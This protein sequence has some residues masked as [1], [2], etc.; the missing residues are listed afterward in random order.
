MLPRL[1]LLLVFALSC[2]ASGCQ[3]KGAMTDGPAAPP[4]LSSVDLTPPPADLDP[5]GDLAIACRPD[6]MEFTRETGC[7]SDDSVEFCLSDG[8]AD[9]LRRVKQAAPAVRCPQKGGG[10]ARCD[11]NT[12]LLCFY[13]TPDPACMGGRLGEVE[14]GELCALSTF[15]EI[16]RIVPTFFE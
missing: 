7:Q 5:G 11:R 14:W 4:D 15:P 13:P 9:L 1:S 16:R 12:E 10:R 8:D 3:R 2:C 6:K